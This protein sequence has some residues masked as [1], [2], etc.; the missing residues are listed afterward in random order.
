MAE[1][2]NPYAAPSA[3]PEPDLEP[4]VTR[5]L[6]DYGLATTTQ[7]LGNLII[8]TIVVLGL[9]IAFMSMLEPGEMEEFASG[10]RG[11]LWGYVLMFVYYFVFEA[12][13]K[14][15]PGKLITGTK[16]VNERGEE[17]TIGQIAGRTVLRFVPFEAFSFLGSRPGWHDRWSNTRVI[18]TRDD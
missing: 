12:T 1:P 4:G 15:T 13:L 3:D 16:V 6:G 10:P 8:D 11:D 14:A 2:K 17:P 7:R 9:L 5:D 18:R